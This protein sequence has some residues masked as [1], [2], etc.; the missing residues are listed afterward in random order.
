MGRSNRSGLKTLL[1]RTPGPKRTYGRVSVGLDPEGR[2]PSLKLP[3]RHRAKLRRHVRTPFRPGWRGRMRRLQ[4]M[5]DNDDKGL[6]ANDELV[7][8][9]AEIKDGSERSLQCL[10]D[11]CWAPLVRAARKLGHEEDKAEE[12]V[13]M[14]FLRVWQKRRHWE[15][16][17]SARA[18]L[19][20]IARM[21]PAPTHRPRLRAAQD[22][23]GLTA[24]RLVAIR[25][26]ASIP[27]T[28]P[29]GRTESGKTAKRRAAVDIALITTMREGMLRR[30]EAAAL[31][32]R[33]LDFHAD[34]SA[35][36]TLQC[37]T[38]DSEEPVVALGPDAASA[39][40]AIRP[41]GA[42]PATRVFGLKSDRSISNRIAA[43]AKAAGLGEGF[44]DRSLRIGLLKDL[45][46]L[47]Q[48]TSHK[49]QIT[50]EAAVL[51][52]TAAGLTRTAVSLETATKPAAA[53]MREAAALMRKAATLETAAFTAIAALTPLGE[54][55]TIETAERETAALTRTTAALTRTA[56]ALTR[57]AAALTRTAARVSHR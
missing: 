56:A 24:D 16:T 23:V 8:L 30:S 31:R 55:A 14:A 54:E 39:L 27:R 42:E 13:Q 40:Q 49:P 37:S 4:L 22:Q 2:L 1:A 46:D 10:I 38:T 11:A 17:G 51:A 34:G 6:P 9:L 50:T 19:Y 33:D 44:S 32:W 28:G 26:T 29:T 45:N 36:A 43:V 7:R 57:T 48:L 35:S 25:N 53:L 41:E 20:R 15:P 3:S 18:Y 21:V 12:I 47:V 5:R 52:R